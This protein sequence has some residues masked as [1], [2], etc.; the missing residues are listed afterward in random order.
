MKGRL[1]SIQ[2]MGALDGPGL[3]TVIILQGCPLKCQFCHSI[4]TTMPKNVTEIEAKDLV[5]KVMRNSQY[6]SKYGTEKDT[7]EIRGGV[8]ITGGD[9]LLQ[10]DFTLE[11]VK[12]F[13]EQ[14]VHVVVE[15]SFYMSPT[16]IDELLPYVDLW[17]VSLK[18]LDNMKHKK[19][20][21]K[22]NKLIL[23]NLKSLD[24]E[25][26]KNENINSKI[27]IRFVVVP[28]LT[29]DEPHAKQLGELCSQIKNIDSL[30]LLPYVSMGRYKWIEIFGKYS[31]E[32][33]PD[34]SHDDLVRIKE[35]IGNVEYPVT[36]FYD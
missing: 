4:D 29:D 34:A 13:K 32:D 2:T 6:W 7:G 35:Y 11:L 17:M 36:G 27:R 19:I 31:L 21:G 12:L 23:D 33:T 20:T 5:E 3:R 24:E 16:V 18:H 1:H 8:T 30:E 10:S 22:P 28:N 9:P 15:S 26:S 25:I 14:N